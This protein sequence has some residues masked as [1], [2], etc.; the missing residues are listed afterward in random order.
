MRLNDFFFSLFSHFN[1]CFLSLRNF[2][3]DV[4]KIE[5]TGNKS[6][7]A[8]ELAVSVM[9][10]SLS[11]RGICPNFVVTRGVF[12]CP[13][14]PPASHWG[15]AEN[16]NH[17]VHANTP[18]AKR[19]PKQPSAKHAGRFQFIRMELCTE[20]DAEEFIKDQPNELLP[21]EMSRILLFQISFALYAGATKFSLKHYDL[22]LLNVFLQKASNVPG[23]KLSATGD[24]V[25]RY[26]LGSKN[27]AL[28]MPVEKALLAKLADYGT[29]DVK[30]ETNGQPLSL[31]QITTPENTPPEFLILG[32]AAKQGHEH[33]LFGLGL[34]M[35]HLFTG[36]APYE[37]I[38]EDVQCPPTFKKML[39]D[40]WE[41][42]S[43]AGYS[44]IRSFVM[45][46]V[47]TDDDG[48]ITEGE[49]DETFYDTL[50]KFLVLFGV[51]ENKF[52]RRQHGRVW[53]AVSD[54]F[55]CPMSKRGKDSTYF[56]RDQRKYSLS[57]GTNKYIARARRNLEKFDG[58]MELLRS[59]VDFDGSKRATALD[60]LNSEFFAP[61]TEVAGTEYRHF[62]DVRSYNAFA[63]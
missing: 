49:A 54:C 8:T 24:V 16:K 50:Y 4:D 52:Q 61:L 46:E 59:L 51:P 12:T 43:V 39:S 32:D 15:C 29:A 1:V 28:R 62:D 63:M 40:L 42:E 23:A 25:L 47:Y 2:S 19:P 26:G 37:E 33:D 11:R 53:K 18:K 14:E 30:A 34:C 55:G 48:N 45:S 22:K 20:G 10:S 41:D 6:V 57:H 35:L 58:G 27:F 13:F 31:A 9:L 38:L 60:V 17:Q 21:I 56:A 44:V 36:S 5:S 7:V 3:R